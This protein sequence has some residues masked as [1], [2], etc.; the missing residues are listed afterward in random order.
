MITKFEEKKQEIINA[1]N[2]KNI[3]CWSCTSNS[4]ILVDGFVNTLIQKEIP[5]PMVIWWESLPMVMLVCNNC[6]HV[7]HYALKALLPNII[8]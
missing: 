8:I 3:K 5:W 2:T 4:L 7:Q 1:L 6:W